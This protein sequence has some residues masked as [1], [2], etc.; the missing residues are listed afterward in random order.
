MELESRLE[1]VT[2]RKRWFVEILASDC[3]A[4]KCFSRDASE[5]TLLLVNYPNPFNPETWL[6][7]HLANASDVRITIYDA[8]GGVV[9]RLDLGHQNAGYYTSRSRAAYWDGRNSLGESVASGVY[10]YQLEADNLSLLR[11]M[12]ILNN[13][14]S[15]NLLSGARLL[16]A[17]SDF[18]N[19]IYIMI[20]IFAVL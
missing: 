18:R 14:L 17:P 4:R 6:P 13:L 10:F 19:L 11:K 3:V 9:H 15:N 2:D 20:I 12:L 16:A 8:R 7:Y 5:E 1:T